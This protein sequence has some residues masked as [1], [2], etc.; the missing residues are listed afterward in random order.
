MLFNSSITRLGLMSSSHKRYFSV[1]PKMQ[2]SIPNSDTKEQSPLVPDI[3]EKIRKS[4]LD[5]NVL[6]KLS[7]LTIARNV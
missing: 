1:K 5:P 7:H 2:L 4:Q 6:S 3:V